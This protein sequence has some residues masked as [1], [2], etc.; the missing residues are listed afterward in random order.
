MYYIRRKGDLYR[1]L[2]RSQSI[3]HR[4]S[5]LPSDSLGYALHDSIHLVDGLIAS[6]RIRKSTGMTR[7]RLHS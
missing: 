1:N 2:R 6:A 4:R 5:E 3:I 7:P